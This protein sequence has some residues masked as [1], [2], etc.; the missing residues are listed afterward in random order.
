MF[1]SSFTLPATEARTRR[2]RRAMAPALDPSQP[3]ALVAVLGWLAIGG[4]A[5]ACLPHARP[6]IELGATLPFWLVGAPLIDLAW[7]MRRRIA[8]STT[9]MLARM[10]ASRPRQRGGA[11][12][13]A[14]PSSRA[15]ASRQA[16]RSSIA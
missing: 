15:L 11:R 8:R 6:G 7:L 1:V 3:F 12:R 9:R 16:R 10:S 2:A 4:L 13:L 5:M 14:G